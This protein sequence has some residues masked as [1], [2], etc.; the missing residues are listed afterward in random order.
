M[1]STQVKGGIDALLKSIHE[2]EKTVKASGEGKSKREVQAVE[3]M[4]KLIEEDLM[5]R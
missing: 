3:W 2:F 5:M 1:C 4:W